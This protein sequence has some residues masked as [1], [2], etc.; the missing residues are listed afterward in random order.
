[1]SRM[2]FSSIALRKEV[3]TADGIRLS[4]KKSGWQRCF[5][6]LDGDL[7]QIWNAGGIL[8]DD[9]FAL[10]ELQTN[11]DPFDVINLRLVHVQ[12]VAEKNC[13]CLHFTKGMERILISPEKQQDD[14]DD[15]NNNNHNDDDGRTIEAWT[16]I[17]NRA[18]RESI[19]LDQY[20]TS[21]FLHTYRSNDILS[22]AAQ[23]SSK[24]IFDESFSIEYKWPG[25]IDFQRCNLSIKMKPGWK[26]SRVVSKRCIS[27]CKGEGP[28]KNTIATISPL[29]S[30]H[31]LSE[32]EGTVILE[33]EG[34]YQLNDQY[35]APIAERIVVKPLQI[36]ELKRLI[37]FLRDTFEV[38][39]P[40][41]IIQDEPESSINL[42][43]IS[44][45]NSEGKTIKSESESLASLAQSKPWN[46]LAWNDL[47]SYY[48]LKNYKSAN[49]TPIEFTTKFKS[50]GF[51]LKSGNGTVVHSQELEDLGKSDE[52][53]R[54]I[55]ETFY[56]HHL[57]LNHS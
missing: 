25:N 36:E 13:L 49:L 40:R 41:P 24:G 29:N 7:L 32:F 27:F 15:N 8:S 38:I 19:L 56:W 33:G 55:L 50:F 57:T 3:I 28:Q 22:F 35:V 34:K 10:E 21:I 4:L 12:K 47:Y 26:D 20:N 17:F 45:E 44:I 54:S 11:S 48:K 37:L 14:D 1:M 18:I 30:F 46:Q 6:R 5:V 23:K 52:K 42:Q 51:C 43:K 16:S 31:L 53:S 9:K 2:N 39:L